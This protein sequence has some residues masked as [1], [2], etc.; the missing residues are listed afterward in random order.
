MFLFSGHGEFETGLLSNTEVVEQ[1]V[2]RFH[3]AAEILA[4][5]SSKTIQMWKITTPKVKHKN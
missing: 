2:K 5:N 4:K 3:P 1:K